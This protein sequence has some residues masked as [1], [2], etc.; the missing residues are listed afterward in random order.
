MTRREALILTKNGFGSLAL[1]SLLGQYST[2]G[3]LAKALTSGLANHKLPH[4]PPKANSVIFLYM[5]GGVSQVDSFDYKPRLEQENGQNP[6]DKF[7][8]EAT[9][10]NEIGTI[11][12]SPWEFNQYGDCGMWVS[13]L[14]PHI[15]TCVD[16]LALVRSMV[17]DFPEHT[18]ANY[19]LHTGHGLQGRPSMGA[20][21]NYGLGSENQDLPGYVVLDGGLIPP[22]GLDNFKSGFLPA[23]FQASILKSGDQPLPNIQPHEAQ[24]SL[25]KQKLDLIKQMDRNFVGQLGQEDEVSSAIDNY[26]LAFRMQASIPELA[27]LNNESRI[28]KK[29]YG[30]DSSNP[31]KAGYAAQCIL[32]RRMVERGVRFIELT[33]P[34][35]EADRWDQHTGL[36]DGHERNAFAV[37]QPIAGLLKD[38]KSRG[39]L[40]TTLVVFAG[41]FG[42]TP[43]AQ[44]VDG[45]DHNP[46]AF[47]IWLAG[48]GIKGGVVY[49]S[50]DDY[51]YRVIDKP[52][53]IHDLHATILYLLGIDHEK[54]TFRFS[55]RDIRLTDV[56]GHVIRDILT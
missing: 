38:L 45:R 17:S 46:S 26:E 7:E 13:D 10:F 1:M 27:A 50:T 19:F 9:Q 14:F 36:K 33:C 30:L 56:H 42:R 53:T 43:F 20:W 12:K 21:I 40:E 18:N 37:D 39:L 31:H 51:G 16:D 54:L 41:E 22:G 6:Y 3:S 32:A 23:S 48:A 55:G 44:G 28:V 29:L 5:D 52:T 11:L 24:S 8:V 35:V 2:A 4:F 25:Q 15:A 34:K 49:G 47:S